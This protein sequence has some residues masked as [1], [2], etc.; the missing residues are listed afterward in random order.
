MLIRVDPSS[1]EPLFI[2]IANSIRS[3]AAAGELIAGD[4]LPAAKQVAASLDLNVHTVLHAYQLLRDEGTIDLR[5]GRGAV[6]T[7]AAE[8]LVEL[9]QDVAELITKAARL[10]MEPA[11]LASLVKGSAT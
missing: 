8:R 6:V 5:R 1:S 9:Q 3:A 4:R 2:Q 10:G 7:D 11:A